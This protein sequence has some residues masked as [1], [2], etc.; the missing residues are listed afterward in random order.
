MG[1]GDRGGLPG[2]YLQ[3]EPE[4][5]SWNQAWLWL[6]S[7]LL[8]HTGEGVDLGVTQQEGKAGWMQFPPRNRQPL[9]R[10]PDRGWEAGMGRYMDAHA[11]W[12]L[13][14]CVVNSRKTVLGF[15][16]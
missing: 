2:F 13:L 8:P 1:G 3:G 7:S 14:P 10:L 12:A 4:K 5:G 16:V 6:C 11:P 15:Q 9:H